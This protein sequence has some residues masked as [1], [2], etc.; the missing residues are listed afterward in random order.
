MQLK[1]TMTWE[2]KF[3]SLSH[4]IYGIL[5]QQPKLG[6]QGSSFR[7]G[8]LQVFR[9]VLIILFLSPSIT[10]LL[11]LILLHSKESSCT[12]E[13]KMALR[14][15]L[16]GQPRWRHILLSQ[17]SQLN[18]ITSHRLC[19]HSRTNLSGQRMWPANCLWPRP[20]VSPWFCRCGPALRTLN[21]EGAMDA[22]D[23]KNTSDH[24][25]WVEPGWGPGYISKTSP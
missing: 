10:L 18:A 13:I 3:C 17:N 19:A 12:S 1:P 22:E 11:S 21:E 2:I 15:K 20:H 9:D 4:L 23:T 16:G 7:H 24:S 14:F 8:W 6:R 25:N 5:W